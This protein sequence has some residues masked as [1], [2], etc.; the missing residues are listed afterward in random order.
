MICINE[1]TDQNCNNKE[2]IS[3]FTILLSPYAPHIAE[4]IWNKLGNSESIFNA[5]FPKYKD[6]LAAN[7]RATRDANLDAI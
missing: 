4:E 2:I 5:I 7:I 1:L 6:E 3:D